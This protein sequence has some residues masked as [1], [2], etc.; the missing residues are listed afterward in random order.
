MTP[1]KLIANFAIKAQ[2]DSQLIAFYFVINEMCYD[3]LG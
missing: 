1:V 2:P 3:G